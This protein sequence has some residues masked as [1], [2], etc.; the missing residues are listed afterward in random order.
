MKY[1]VAAIVV[2]AVMWLDYFELFEPKKQ[3]LAVAVSVTLCV[4]I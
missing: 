3:K 2:D 4:F 1:F